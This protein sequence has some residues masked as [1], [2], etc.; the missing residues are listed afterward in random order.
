MKYI[1]ALSDVQSPDIGDETKIW[2]FVVVLEGA[3][4]GS[5]C[6][7]CANCFIESDVI[8]GNDVTVKSG[9]SLWNGIEI[10]D[11]AFVGP[12][13]AFT[14]DMRPRSKRR[15]LPFL[16]TIIG[17]GASLGANATILPG[18]KI[19]QYAM[20]GAGSVVTKNVAPHALHYGS[21]ARLHGYVCDCGSPILPGD[22]CPECGFGLEK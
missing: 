15:R 19:G 16:R 21:P 13:V 12:S 8:I 3:K 9:V 20:I 17:K 7:I 18:I 11:G 10:E 22:A 14:N 5:R 2:Q 1:H 6:N 4:I